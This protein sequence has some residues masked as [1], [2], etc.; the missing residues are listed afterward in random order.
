MEGVSAAW[1]IK[2]LLVR[3][4]VVQS[5]ASKLGHNSVGHASGEL[6]ENKVGTVLHHFLES[7]SVAERHAFI[8]VVKAQRRR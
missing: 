4:D 5:N 3:G 2:G 8:F 6:G 7:A 1:P